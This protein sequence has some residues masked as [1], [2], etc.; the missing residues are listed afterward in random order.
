MLG[1]TMA[2][3]KMALLKMGSP[4]ISIQQQVTA[5]F[6]CFPSRR[7]ACLSHASVYSYATLV[8]TQLPDAG[9]HRGAGW[10]LYYWKVM[11]LGFSEMLFIFLL[12]LIIFGPK[13]LPEIGRQI[14]KALAEF[15]RASNDF[16]AQLEAEMRQIE[17]EQVLQKE[18]ESLQQAILPPEGTVIN[19]SIPAESG[20]QPAGVPSERIPE[21][22]AASAESNQQPSSVTSAPATETEH[23]A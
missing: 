22:S 14:G 13:K 7:N 4:C 15:K 5:E 23:H 20:L 10:V 19:G 1:Y 16:K 3:L 2:L 6:F 17:I 12:A 8:N 11:N 18:K 9:E 21:L